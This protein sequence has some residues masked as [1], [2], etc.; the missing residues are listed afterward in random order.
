MNRRQLLATASLSLAAKAALVGE[1]A[2]TPLPKVSEEWLK[3]V[4][5]YFVVAYQ[6]GD[7]DPKETRPPLDDGDPFVKKGEPRKPPLTVISEGGYL[8]VAS[9]VARVQRRVSLDHAQFQSI[10]GPIFDGTEETNVSECYDP[11]HVIVAYDERGVP[12][13]AIEIC[14]S[15][16]NI[17]IFPGGRDIRNDCHDLRPAAHLL[18][19]LG[20]PLGEKYPSLKEYDADWTRRQKEM[21][22]YLKK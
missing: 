12:T 13:G 6:F 17:H 10:I 1:E 22:K 5:P 16:Q 8:D 3:K 15:C 18:F 7:A 2:K 20:L 19:K 21:E 9:L 11:H 14:F 4:H